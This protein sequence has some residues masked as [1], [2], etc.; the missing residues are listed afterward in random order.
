MRESGTTPASHMTP[1][2]SEAA[3]QQAEDKAR[4]ERQRRAE[5]QARK[6]KQKRKAASS[7]RKANRKNRK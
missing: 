3:R 6:E 1:I 7:A 5:A 4:K 2:T